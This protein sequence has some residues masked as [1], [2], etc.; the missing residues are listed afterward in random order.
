[1]L[2]NL[3]L[4]EKVGQ[5][6]LLAFSG[7][8]PR[9]V[10]KL[11]Q[12]YGIGGCYVSNSNASHVKAARQLSSILQSFAMN[13]RHK[14][15]LILGVD[16]EGTWGVCIS[17]TTTGPGNLAL[18]ATEDPSIT[19]DMYQVIGTE[20]LAIGY[21]AIF[22][23]CVDVIAP[24]WNPIL[25]MRSFGQNPLKVAEHAESAVKGARH[26][27]I[28]STAKHFPGHGHAYI[29]T[30]RDLPVVEGSITELEKRDFFPFRK[31]IDAGVDMVMTSHIIFPGIDAKLPATLSPAIMTDLLRKQM[32]FKGVVITDSMNMGAMKKHFKPEE[33][34]VM[35]L[36]AGVDMIMLAEEHYDHDPARYLENQINLIESVLRAVQKGEISE[37]RINQSVL[38]ILSLK[39]RKGLF[40]YDES[41]NPHLSV[42]GCEKHREVEKKAAE[43]SVAIL[44][45]RNHLIPLSP[46]K[47]Y[48]LVNPVPRKEY[49][50]LTSTRGIGPNQGKPAF[51][52]FR[53][54]LINYG[55]PIPTLS[56]EDLQ[57]GDSYRELFNSADA[58][59]IVTEDYTIPGVDFN[60]RKQINLVQKI[61]TFY[62]EKIGVIALRPPFD[63]T[64]YREISTYLCTFSSRWCAAR[65]AAKAVVGFI[66]PSNRSPVEIFDRV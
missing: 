40:D 20:M 9:M 4:R 39:E 33:S 14:I 56:Y 47:K 18:G 11:I 45:Q 5:L 10:E 15:P 27:G 34:A 31:A 60:T 57:A 64:N 19:Q 16:Q 35:A 38:R 53:E 63:L 41:L 30:H 7:D 50:I 62:K 28:I 51:D 2:S 12:D 17:E 44:R 6:F 32:G 55:F 59:L 37:D 22:A 48:V 66:L 52:V 49:D 25:G 26:S 36:L 43:R 13:T 29:D 23:P 42:V 24:P 46:L 65:A 3:S 1:M 58:I 61:E 8:D 21:N 54:E